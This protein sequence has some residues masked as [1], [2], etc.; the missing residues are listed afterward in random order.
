[1]SLSDVELVNL[2]IGNTTANPY[3]P[4]QMVTYT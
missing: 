3:Y 2:S 4:I 1:M